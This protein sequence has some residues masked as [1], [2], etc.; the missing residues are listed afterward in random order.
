MAVKPYFSAPGTW[1][2]M[3]GWS[4][5]YLF[6]VFR[7]VFASLHCPFPVAHKWF[8][9]LS[10]FVYKCNVSLDQLRLSWL[11]LIIITRYRLPIIAFWSEWTKWFVCKAWIPFSGRM[12]CVLHVGREIDKDF[13]GIC[14]LRHLQKVWIGR[15]K[16]FNQSKNCGVLVYFKPIPWISLTFHKRYEDMSVVSEWI[17]S[18]SCKCHIWTKDEYYSRFLPSLPRMVE[19]VSVGS[20]Y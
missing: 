6:G 7:A 3:F 10:G 4:V 15:T 13:A 16:G 1:K 8:C 20:K 14:D 19:V 5:M 17:G 18:I 12:T 2:E 9:L 11:V